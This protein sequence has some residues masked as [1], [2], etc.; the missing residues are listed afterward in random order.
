MTWFS[1]CSL[2]YIVP[3]VLDVLITPLFHVLNKMRS[4]VKSRAVDTTVSVHRDL[5]PA[6][7]RYRMQCATGAPLT[8]I[9]APCGRPM[10][11]LHGF[12]LP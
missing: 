7:H 1:P 4:A 6:L 3:R 5:T 11:I 12:N 8:A 9:R 10:D 2:L